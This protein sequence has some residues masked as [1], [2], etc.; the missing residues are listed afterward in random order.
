[1]RFGRRGVPM[2]GLF[3]A[4]VGRSLWA[5]RQP[6]GHYRLGS[7]MGVVVVNGRLTGRATP[8]LAGPPGACGQVF[9]FIGG[10]CS[11]AR[12]ILAGG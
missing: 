12:R 11:A 5:L 8:P 4:Q 9:G 3:A 7:T 10:G 6:A 2:L 1:M